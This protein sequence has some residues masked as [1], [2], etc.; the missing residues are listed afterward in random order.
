MAI[1]PGAKDC[2]IKE[3]IIEDL[4]T[5]LTLQFSAYDDETGGCKLTLIGPGLMYGNR[6]LIFNKEGE[7]VASG[8]ATAGFC[9]PTWLKKVT[10]SRPIV[11]R[12]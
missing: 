1:K 7:M 4:V 6:D 12:G 11:A 10:S 9:R 5:G 2:I 8:T 3:Q